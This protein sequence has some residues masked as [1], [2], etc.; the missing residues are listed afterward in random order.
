VSGPDAAPCQDLGMGSVGTARTHLIVIRGDSGSGKSTLAR[1]IRGELD[2]PTALVEQDYFRWE[3][4]TGGV[5]EQRARHAATMIDGVVRTA[6]D[7]EY[8][9]I[10]EGVL[11]LRD[12]AGLLESLHR[13]HCGQSLFLQFDIGLP[14]TIE[15]H[16][17]RPEKQSL[18]TVEELA[19]WYDG[20]QPLPFVE[21][22]RLGPDDRP[23]DVAR[24]LRTQL[25]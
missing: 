6:L 20:W 19:Q 8:D 5:K 9:V 7:Q 2:R 12:Y 22:Q 10:L 14:A 16:R 11:N 4:L 18:F 24:R 13:E 23:E 17:M 21:E 3:L 15:R 25:R 1:A